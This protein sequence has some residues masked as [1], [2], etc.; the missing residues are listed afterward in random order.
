MRAL[1]LAVT[2][3]V[4][5]LC[6]EASLAQD[7]DGLVART[8]SGP[9]R[10]V[11]N[12]A[13]DAFLGIPYAA[14]PVGDKRWRPPQPA[15]SWKD[16]REAKAFGA[17]CAAGKSTN[18]PRS[19]AEDCLFINVWRP[20]N[21]SADAR[22]PVYVFIHGGGFIN[23][24]SNQA[25]MTDIVEKTGVVGVSFNYRLGALGLFL[26]SGRRQ[27]FRRLRL[28]GSAGGAAL[29]SRKHRRVR[30]RS[31]AGHARRRVRRRLF[32]LRASG[33]ARFGWPLRSGDD[34]KR[35]VHQRSSGSS[36]KIRPRDLRCGRVQ[37]AGRGRV[38]AL[39]SGWQAHRRAVSTIWRCRVSDRR[40]QSPAD[41]ATQ[42]GGGRNPSHV[43]RS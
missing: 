24:S 6:G 12:G 25:D 15:D 17:Y 4:I 3:C 40:N 13:V 9:V 14:P 2:A 26:P 31:D 30:R 43:W 20:S 5:G 28:D 37:R 38:P 1:C 41:C 36:A 18:G 23:G 10:G 35:L 33:R 11:H 32:G 34:A 39:R 8:E 22:L 16:T 21:V 42:G 7:G 27:G 19:E 29:G